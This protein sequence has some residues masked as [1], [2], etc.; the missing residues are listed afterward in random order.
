MHTGTSNI[1]H[2]TNCVGAK[3]NGEAQRSKARVWPEVR[4]ALHR[5]MRVPSGDFLVLNGKLWVLHDEVGTGLVARILGVSTRRVQALCDEGVLME[6]RDWRKK[7]C[8]GPNGTYLIRKEA[9]MKLRGLE[10][11]EKEFN[12]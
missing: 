2:R 9:V 12:R 11:G 4:E 1:E 6:G 7:P 8:G 5:W 3:S 10:P